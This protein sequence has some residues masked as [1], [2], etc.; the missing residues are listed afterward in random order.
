MSDLLVII[1]ALVAA[2]LAFRFIAGLVKFAVLAAIVIAV[3]YFLSQ[4]AM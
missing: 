4:G 2:F 1:L 3:I